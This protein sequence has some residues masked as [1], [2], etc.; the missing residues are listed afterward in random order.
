MDKTLQIVDTLSKLGERFRFPDLDR[1]IRHMVCE[2]AEALD[3]HLRMTDTGETR[4]HQ[5]DY[6]LEI[7]LGQVIIMATL[8]L[9]NMYSSLDE[10]VDKALEQMVKDR[11]W[12]KQ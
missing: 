2:A 9:Y 10:A 1:A 8:A 11:Q 5:K 7:E 3:A 6:D 4:A 12:P